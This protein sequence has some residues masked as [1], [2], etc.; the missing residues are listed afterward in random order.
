MA[1]QA[2]RDG[3]DLTGTFSHTRCVQ[4][5]PGWRDIKGILYPIQPSTESCNVG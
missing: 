3:I 2:V 5:A 4:R 1:L